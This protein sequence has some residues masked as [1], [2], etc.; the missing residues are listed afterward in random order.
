MHEPIQRGVRQAFQLA[1]RY[2]I[3]DREALYGQVFHV[4]PQD[5]FQYLFCQTK[6]VRIVGTEKIHCARPPQLNARVKMISG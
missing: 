4:D 3:R 2:R 5:S 1:Q 6:S